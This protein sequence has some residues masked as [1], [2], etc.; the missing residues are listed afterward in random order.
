M[1]GYSRL[2]SKEHGKRFTNFSSLA[3]TTTNRG[4]ID[5]MK[6]LFLKPIAILLGVAD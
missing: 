1:N 3:Y 2:L 6:R 5:K 4:I